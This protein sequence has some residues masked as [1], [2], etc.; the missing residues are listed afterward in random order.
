VVVP[1]SGIREA[2]TAELIA[3][4]E[5][6]GDY[7]AVNSID[8]ITQCIEDDERVNL[9]PYRI[10]L[11]PSEPAWLEADMPDSADSSMVVEEPEHMPPTIVEPIAPSSVGTSHDPML[12]TVLVPSRTFRPASSTT[13]RSRTP[14]YGALSQNAT[15]GPSRSR[16]PIAPRDYQDRG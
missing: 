1:E 2:N 14:S 15:A 12:A 10:T 9:D 6:V 16:Q 13:E 8:W 4:I 11:Q 7:Q 5:A 3:L